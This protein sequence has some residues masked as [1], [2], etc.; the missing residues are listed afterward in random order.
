MSGLLGA[1]GL[2][3]FGLGAG[4]SGSVTPPDVSDV[5]AIDLQRVRSGRPGLTVST[6]ARRSKF[7]GG[8]P[9]LDDVNGSGAQ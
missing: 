1:V 5:L 6:Q 8:R 9:T 2:G 7:G 3:V 4:L